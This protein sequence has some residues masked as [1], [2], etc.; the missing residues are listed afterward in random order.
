MAAEEIRKLD[1]IPDAQG[2]ALG[3]IEEGEPAQI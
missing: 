2:V 1:L 3:G